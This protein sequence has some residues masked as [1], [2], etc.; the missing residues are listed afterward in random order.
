[1]TGEKTSDFET[2]FHEP[3]ERAVDELTMIIWRL[4]EQT[5]C[6]G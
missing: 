4:H 5:E 3:E 2:G 6:K 1:M